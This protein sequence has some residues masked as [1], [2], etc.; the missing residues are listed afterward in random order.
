[1]VQLKAK[2]NIIIDVLEASI[3]KLST[4]GIESAANV[5]DVQ[6]DDYPGLISEGNVFRKTWSY[7]KYWRRN[8]LNRL[9]S[10]Q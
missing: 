1:M 9:R 8:I 4:P 5:Q 10:H 7:G 6:I 2:E 3:I